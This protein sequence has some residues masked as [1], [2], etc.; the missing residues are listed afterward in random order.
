[1]KYSHLHDSICIFPLYHVLV[2]DHFCVWLSST[3]THYSFLTY[4]ICESFLRKVCLRDQS[5]DGS[6]DIK[7][8]PSFCSNLG[9]PIFA[10]GQIGTAVRLNPRLDADDASKG[11]PCLK[12]GKPP[13]SKQF[14]I[15]LFYAY[16]ASNIIFCLGTKCQRHSLG[17]GTFFIGAFSL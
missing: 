3:S 2:F 6:G 7:H 5:Q 17:S 14:V 8:Q 15:S 12:N 11:S 1:M 4:C 16:V 13:R 10:Q 9:T